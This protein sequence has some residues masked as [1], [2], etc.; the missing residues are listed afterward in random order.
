[1]QNKGFFFLLPTERTAQCGRGCVLVASIIVFLVICMISHDGMAAGKKNK[2]EQKILFN[3]NQVFYGT[4]TGS[5]ECQRL[6]SSH[7]NDIKQYMNDG[8]RVISSTS[9]ELVA[10]AFEEGVTQRLRRDSFGELVKYDV[11]YSFGCKC[12][13]TE[14]IIER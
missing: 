6:C 14:Y 13:G 9:K 11:P 10:Q 2:L 1:M 7:V 12:I 5:Q 4:T 3:A 8:W